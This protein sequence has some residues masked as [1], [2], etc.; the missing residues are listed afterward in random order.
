MALKATRFACQ[1]NQVIA[2]GNAIWVEGARERRLISKGGRRPIYVNKFTKN[3]DD[4]DTS[5]HSLS[6]ENIL[7]KGKNFY[8]LF[9]NGAY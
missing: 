4:K 6:Y 2:K 3:K 8:D 1:G 9:D 7:R 5:F